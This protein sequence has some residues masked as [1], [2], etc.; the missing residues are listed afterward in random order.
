[1]LKR[2][3]QYVDI[4]APK[5]LSK[6]HNNRA[7]KFQ[8]TH[9][10]LYEKFYAHQMWMSGC[11][12]VNLYLSIMFLFLYFRINDRRK[13]ELFQHQRWKMSFGLARIRWKTFLYFFIESPN[14]E[15]MKRRDDDS[16]CRKKNVKYYWNIYLS[17]ALLKPYFLRIISPSSSS[18][19]RFTGIRLLSVCGPSSHPHSHQHTLTHVMDTKLTFGCNILIRLSHSLIHA[20]V[21]W[22]TLTHKHLQSK[23]L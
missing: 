21:L 4:V 9:T 10:L 16:K 13:K 11:H 19:T 12:H 18:V 23:K 22:C 6:C 17:R 20:F 8:H 3:R 15:T 14:S 2:S 1:M 7:K 5:N